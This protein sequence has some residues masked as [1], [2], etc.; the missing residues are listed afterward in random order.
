MREVRKREKGNLCGATC[1]MP[2]ARADAGDVSV[3]E[4]RT[5]AAILRPPKPAGAA[6]PATRLASH[7]GSATIG[8]LVS[9]RGGF[10]VD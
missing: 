8:K 7:L 4:I 3:V 5:H 9:F 6:K 10:I 1:W 2:R